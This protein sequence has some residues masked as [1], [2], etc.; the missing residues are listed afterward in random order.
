MPDDVTQWLTEEEA[1]DYEAFYHQLKEPGIMTHYVRAL[2]SLAECRR[3]MEKH[4]FDYYDD[5]G[6]R[7]PCA[8]CLEC[9]A[10]YYHEHDVTLI[11]ATFPAK[12]E[13]SG[14]H[15]KPDCAWAKCIEGLPRKGE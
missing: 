11:E 3:L 9:G 13:K 2:A 4:E 1:H 8:H 15:H 14:K 5:Q 7:N 6:Q 10:I 12:P